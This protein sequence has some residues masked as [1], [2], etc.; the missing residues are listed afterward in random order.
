[1]DSL[2]WA[3][4]M[5]KD[6]LSEAG[7]KALSE[8][9][10]ITGIVLWALR[11]HFKKIEGALS[12]VAQNVSELGKALTKVETSHAERIGRLEVEVTEIKRKL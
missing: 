1:M 6:F 9:V 11:G 12:T 5:G 7:Q 10:I 4:T 2:V 8:Q 3:L